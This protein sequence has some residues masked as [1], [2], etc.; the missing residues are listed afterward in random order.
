MKKTNSFIL[1]GRA[2]KYARKDFWVSVQV[3]FWITVVLAVVFYI[4]EH[5]IQPEEYAN[6]WDAIVWAF[7]RYIGDPGHFAGKGPVTLVGRYIDTVIG[8]L[9][10]LI[11]A[12]PAGLVSNGFRKAMDEDKRRMHLEMCRERIAKSF[13]R[14]VNKAT[15]YRVPPRNLSL[16]TLQAKKGM[17]ENDIID[18]VTRYPEFRLRNLATSQVHSERPQ[19]RLVIEMIPF[20]QQTVDG[21]AI[22]RTCYG[23]K[24]DRKSKVTII[25]PTSGT[26]CTI[27]Y[28]SYYVAQF[29]GFNFISREFVE[30][31]DD[32]VS[33]YTIGDD[34]RHGVREFIDDIKQL[35]SSKDHWNIAMISSDNMYDTQIHIVHKTKQG[36]E[37]ATSVLS[38]EQFQNFYE[39]LTETMNGKHRLACDVD[40]KY[41]P[42]GPKNIVVK[43]GGGKENSGFT[44][45]ISYSVTTWM[46]SFTPI[47]V[48][49]A[50]VIRQNMEEE[51]K[52]EFTEHS[53][54][55]LQGNGFGVNETSNN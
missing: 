25:A 40:D 12:V 46:D 34:S 48:D 9:K 33:F 35:S 26:E 29:G 3:L 8:I 16:V 5:T 47:A 1:F 11:F 18:T 4:V 27:G 53:G 38:E 43:T 15:R 45:R 6:P 31:V 39:Q 55:K 24:I 17:T 42:V 13:R 23:I 14:T 30:N 28:F 44:M 41:R 54:W 2:F 19:D 7:T 51:G 10:I 49:I 22:E 50:K 52:R 20:D 37:T 36:E 32:P 21:Y